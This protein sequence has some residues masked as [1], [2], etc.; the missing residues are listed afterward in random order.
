MSRSIA[1]QLAIRLLRKGCA[2]RPFYHIVVVPV[3]D[4]CVSEGI[5]LIGIYDPLPNER[6]EKLI[7][8]NIDRFKY[9][10]AQGAWVKTQVAMLLGAA[11]VWPLHPHSLTLAWRARQRQVASETNSSETTN[12]N[13]T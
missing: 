11:G 6:N 1:N 8:L 5:E 13:T 3:L 2:N 4:R 9:Y 10:V 12:D 7:S